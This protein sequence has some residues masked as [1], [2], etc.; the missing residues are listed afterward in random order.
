MPASGRYTLGSE[1]DSPEEERSRSIFLRSLHRED[2]DQLTAFTSTDSWKMMQIL[3]AS[4]R[5]LAPGDG[6]GIGVS[7]ARGKSMAIHVGSGASATPEKAVYRLMRGQSASNFG[8]VPE[9]PGQLD[10]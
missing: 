3:H 9:S 8:R 2:A 1:G 4:F 5:E 6:T 10:D 7:G